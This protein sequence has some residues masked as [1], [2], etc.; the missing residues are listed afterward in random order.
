M[1]TL[2]STPKISIKEIFKANWPNYLATH[3]DSIPDYVIIT[4]EKM[5]SCRDPEKLGYHKYACP[6]HPDQYIVV[7]LVLANLV[8]VIVVAGFLLING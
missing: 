8:S 7:P 1:E 2:S 4:I 6:D 5:L 3:Q